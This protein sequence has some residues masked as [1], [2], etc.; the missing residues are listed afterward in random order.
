MIRN[1]LTTACILTWIV[2]CVQEP[3]NVI[4]GEIEGLEVGDKIILSVEDIE[5]SMWIATD[6]AIVS[7]AGEFTLVTG[8]TGSLVQLTRLRAGEAF[9]PRDRHEPRCFLEGFAELRVTGSV[10]EWDDMKTSG[11]LYAHPDMQVF[12]R[13]A[14]STRVI[15]DELHAINDQLLKEID[16]LNN[17]TMAINEAK[18]YAKFV[19]LREQGRGISRRVD[20]LQ[21]AFREKYPGMAYSAEILRRDYGLLVADLDKYEE[22]FHALSP[23]VRE[24]PA[25]QM[26]RAQ[27]DDFRASKIG[28]V[29]PDFTRVDL[30]GREVT[31]SA[32]RGKYVLLDFWGTWCGPSKMS[33]PVLV[34]LYAALQAKGANIEFIGISCDEQNDVDWVKAIEEDKLA[35]IQVNDT[36]PGTPKSIRKRFATLTAVPTSILISPEGKILYKDFAALVIPKVKEL[37]GL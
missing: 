27:V 31:L 12:P 15:M 9:N 7:K 32:F 2:S 35:W 18:T 14:D 34:E 21:V 20:S 8:A 28:A 26:L 4:K 37:F 19:K 24:S 3:R 16:A 1:L 13:L 23:A 22:A 11:G 25:G 29:A 33:R 17:Q 30:N 5:G 36:Y 10:E 6:S